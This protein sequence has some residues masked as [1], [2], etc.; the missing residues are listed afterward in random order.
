M[1]L[2]PPIPLFLILQLFTVIV[3]SQGTVQ[4]SPSLVPPSTFSDPTSTSTSS[5]SSN[6]TGTGTG[7]AAANSTSLSPTATSTANFPSLSNVS[8]CGESFFFFLS[9][10]DRSTQST[11]FFFAVSNCLAEGSA[12]LNCTSVVD[13]NCFCVKYVKNKLISFFSFL[14]LLVFI[15][16]K[17]FSSLY[18]AEI[19][20]CVLADCSDQVS[21]IESL[22]QQFCN[23]ASV[24]PTLTF[25]AVPT[26]TTFSSTSTTPSTVTTTSS[27]ASSTA[28]TN[29]AT[30]SWKSTSG[31]TALMGFG[32]LL[33]LRVVLG[34]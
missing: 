18:P 17:H 8:P 28:S 27:T 10:F 13:V 11:H 26:T 16:N 19:V 21:V 3:C 22:G 33:V 12:R 4:P 32:V 23:I 25:P 30:S 29:G 9:S 14:L 34:V 5:S 2:Y 6:S 7:T 15:L 1:N 20:D 24:H 31:S